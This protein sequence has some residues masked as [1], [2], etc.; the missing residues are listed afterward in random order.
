M[1]VHAAFA[2]I[3]AA[4]PRR[5]GTLGKMR[6]SSVAKSLREKL[7]NKTTPEKFAEAATQEKFVGETTQEILTE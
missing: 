4:A 3:L 5:E 6:L 7:T 2:T 1:I